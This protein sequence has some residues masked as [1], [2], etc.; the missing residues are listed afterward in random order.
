VFTSSATVALQEHTL[1]RSDANTH[2]DF[3]LI[4]QL[5]LASWQAALGSTELAQHVIDIS[6]QQPSSGSWSPRAISQ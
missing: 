6:L 2:Q 3:E 5:Q 1:F 4:Y